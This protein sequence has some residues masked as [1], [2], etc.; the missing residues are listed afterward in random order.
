MEGI[1]VDAVLMES[2]VLGRSGTT[3]NGDA[4]G[5]VTVTV[6]ALMISRTSVLYCSALAHPVSRLSSLEVLILWW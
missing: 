3:E 6:C 5:T 2:D 1:V 4:S